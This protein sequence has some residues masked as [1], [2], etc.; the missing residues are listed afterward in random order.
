MTKKREFNNTQYYCNLNSFDGRPLAKGKALVP[1]RTD[2]IELRMGDYIPDNLTSV[3][4]DGFQFEIGFMSIDES[5]YAVYMQEFQEEIAAELSKIRESNCILGYEK[6]GEPVFCLSFHN[7]S[8][9]PNAG[10]R[11]CL[12]PNY[13]ETLSLDFMCENK[14]FDI[15]DDRQPS[16]EKQDLTRLDFL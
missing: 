15:A 6:N 16:V 8:D 7:C 13:I 2:V 1:F 11:S 9:C 4:I 14:D 12:N 10:I 5:K 3:Q